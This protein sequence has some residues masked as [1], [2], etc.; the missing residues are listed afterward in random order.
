MMNYD[1][2]LIFRKGSNNKVVDALS[3]LP[4]AKFNAFS[5][6]DSDLIHR[7]QQSWLKDPAMVHLLHKAKNSPKHDNKY[8]WANN[9]LKRK[10]KVLIGA[11]DELR[12]ELLSYFH[13]STQDGHSSIEVTMKKLAVVVY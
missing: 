4:L 1:Y 5:I 9:Q 11:N 2:T 7:I 6:I 13:N 3:R 10:G 12:N 8:S